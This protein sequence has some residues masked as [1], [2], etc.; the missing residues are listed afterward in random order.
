MAVMIVCSVAVTICF[1]VFAISFMAYKKEELEYKVESEKMQNDLIEKTKDDDIEL[2]RCQV[3]KAKYEAEKE[4]CKCDL[5][6][7][8]ERTK[9]LEIKY[10]AKKEFGERCYL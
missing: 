9:Q 5:E 1:S 10:N 7:E 3:E 8:K 2:E 4:K 6:A